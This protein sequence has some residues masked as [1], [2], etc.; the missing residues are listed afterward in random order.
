[1]TD[2]HLLTAPA[3]MRHSLSSRGVDPT[4]S[5]SLTQSVYSFEVHTCMPCFRLESCST[6][7]EGGGEGWGGQTLCI[8]WLCCC[9]GM[10]VPAKVAV[11]MLRPCPG[12]RTEVVVHGWQQ[13]PHSCV[14][15]LFA[16]V[17]G[18]G[19]AIAKMLC[20]PVAVIVSA[21]VGRVFGQSWLTAPAR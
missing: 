13:L 10:V 9:C 1:M 4:S 19:S 17:T 7:G 11:D 15:Y 5:S 20:L 14:R 6:R 8:L 3:H 2:S 16:C 21:L 12:C 18:V